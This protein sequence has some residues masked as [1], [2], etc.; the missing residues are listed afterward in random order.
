MKTQPSLLIPL[1]L[2][3]A[4]ALSELAASAAVFT[5]NFESLT[6]GNNLAGQDNWTGLGGDAFIVSTGSGTNTSTV[7][8]TA[9]STGSN[10]AGRSNDGTFSFGSLSGVTSLTLGFDTRYVDGG[11]G[12]V[13]NQSLFYLNSSPIASTQSAFFGLNGNGLVI[14]GSG[15]V[16]P[17]TLNFDDWISLQLVMDLTANG[18]DGSGSLFYKNLTDGDLGYSAVSGLQD[19]NL[20]LT[21][22]QDPTQ[23]NRMMLRTGLYEGNKIDNLYIE[24]TAAPEPSRTLLAALGICGIILRRK[25]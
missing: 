18:G 20:N 23:W 9:G 15:P 13:N 1:I 8:G 4:L 16:L 25:R 24:T 3:V 17:G 10:F 11:N 12:G 5:Y 2:T 6:S 21:S 19:I 22:G 7:V 14:N